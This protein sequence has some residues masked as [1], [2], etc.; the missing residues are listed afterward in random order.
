MNPKTTL[1][2]VQQGTSVPHWALHLLP[3][4]SWVQEDTRFFYPH[5]GFRIPIKK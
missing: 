5:G 3:Y 2:V 1:C 4:T